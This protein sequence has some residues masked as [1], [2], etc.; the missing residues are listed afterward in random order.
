MRSSLLVIWTIFLLG[1]LGCEKAADISSPVRYE[2][3]NI[4]FLYPHNWKVTEDVKRQD[5]HYI[6]VESPGDAISIVQIYSKSVFV[7]LS[8][9]VEW[10]SSQS[11]E[12]TS[13]GNVGKSSFSTIERPTFSTGLKGTK[14]NFTIN[15]LGEQLPHIRE[16]YAMDS[17]NKVAFLVAQT[18]TED[19]SKVEPGFNLILRSIVVE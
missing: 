12:E 18:A 8:E 5:I 19:L 14:E 1:L 3:E 9:F 7:S 10:F 16:Y 4:S 17:N 13:A 11:R 15:I 6:F 2:K